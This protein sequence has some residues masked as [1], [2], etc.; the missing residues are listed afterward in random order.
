MKTHHAITDTKTLADWLCL[1]ERQIYRLTT[2]GVLPKAKRRERDLKASV[3]GY[4]RHMQSIVQAAGRGQAHAVSA[5]ASDDPD[6]LSVDE[7]VKYWQAVRH[8]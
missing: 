1:S 7:R 4:V 6:S 5:G 8:Q 3:Q 2:D